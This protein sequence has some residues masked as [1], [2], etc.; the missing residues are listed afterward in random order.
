MDISP[1]PE[2][3]TLFTQYEQY[4]QALDY[5]GVGRL[6]GSKLITAGPRDITFHNNNFITRWRF[7]KSMKLL[8]GEAGLLSMRIQ[9]IA[10]EIISDQ[11]SM[12]KVTWAATFKKT[13]EQPLIFNISYLVRKKRRRAEIIALIAHEDEKKIL[14]GYGLIK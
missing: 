2:V 8:Y 14:E 3:E 1:T 6:Y 13:R 7:D 9:H 5:K 4:S 11:Y 12:V 10:E